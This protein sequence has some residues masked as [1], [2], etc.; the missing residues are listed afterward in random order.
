MAWF[1]RSFKYVHTRIQQI[2][3]KEITEDECKALAISSYTCKTIKPLWWL[4]PFISTSPPAV[5]SNAVGRV[6]LSV[7]GG[8]QINTFLL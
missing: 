7:S 4:D 3:P 2:Y 8:L 6:S 1:I 5:F